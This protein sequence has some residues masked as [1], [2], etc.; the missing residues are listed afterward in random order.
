MHWQLGMIFFHG[1]YR[2]LAWFTASSKY[3]C[4]AQYIEFLQQVI[5]TCQIFTCIIIFSLEKNFV[6]IWMRGQNLLSC[7]SD[8]LMKSSFRLR[9]SVIVE[10]ERTELLTLL[11]PWSNPD[12]EM[13]GLRSGTKWIYGSVEK[14]NLG[15]KLASGSSG[16]SDRN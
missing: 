5:K 1:R 7:R 3:I 9:W 10:D 12:E 15:K 11:N 6:L 16:L 2:E 13:W 4:K 8:K 14:G